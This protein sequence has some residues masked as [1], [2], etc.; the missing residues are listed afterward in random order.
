MRPPVLSVILGAAALAIVPLAAAATQRSAAT[1][2]ATTDQP[3]NISATSAKLNGRA[4]L[5]CAGTRGFKLAYPDHTTTISSAAGAGTSSFNATVTNLAPGT[6][7]AYTAFATDCAG[8]ATGNPVGFTT[9]ARV[10]LTISGS[11]KVSGGISCTSSCSADVTNG[12][13]MTL[14]ASPSSGSRF[15]SW[16][17]LCAGQTQTCTATPTGTAS[18][19]ATFGAVHTLTVTKT[20]DGTGTVAT[21]GGEIACGSTCSAAFTSGV[22]VTLTATPASDSIFLGWTGGCTGATPSC[23]VSLGS[24]QAVTAAFAKEKKLSVDVH[25]RGTVT[26]SPA[27]LVCTGACSALVAPGT[28]VAL[29]AQAADGWRFVGWSAPCSGTRGCSVTMT[30][31]ATINAEFRPVFVLRVIT[32]GGR[33]VVRSAPNGILCGK[34]CSKAFLQGAVVTLRAKAAKGYR[35]TGWAGDCRGAKAT[36]VVTL[37]RARAVVALYA[38]L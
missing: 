21:S 19:T 2:S 5:T 32:A 14:T 12:K 24:D 7:Y 37:S 15:V 13:Q 3:S 1:P 18:I 16:G 17:G 10:N 35:F 29:A 4:T 34:Y 38:K 23:V 27:G 33:G 25:G 11:G 22:S 8:T 28:I 26:S 36:C 20:G 30:A 9:L 31:D 6:A